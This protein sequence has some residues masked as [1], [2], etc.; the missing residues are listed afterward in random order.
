M[1]VYVIRHGET[2]W[3]RTGQLQGSADNP[4]NASGLR[5]A[6][7]ASLYLKSIPFDHV[8]SSPLIRAKE[9]CRIILRDR[10]CPVRVLDSITELD[11]GVYEGD[12]IRQI[13]TDE[14][15]PVHW[16]F[17]GPERYVPING[18]ESLE[19]L[20]E[21]CGDFVNNSLLPLEGKCRHLLVTAHGAFIKGLMQYLEG[22]GK[23]SFWK[24]NPSGNCAMT[25]LDCTGGILTV[26]CEGKDIVKETDLKSNFIYL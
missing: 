13:Q 2:E 8:Y 22:R 20:Q 16:F 14:T 1:K 5:E 24:G 12:D 3:N 18:A 7:A 23:D 6:M 19:H 10:E 26:E 21:R 11:Y 25:V 4:L 15:H 9:T 17:C